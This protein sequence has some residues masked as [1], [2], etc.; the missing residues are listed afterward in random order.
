MKLAMHHQE[1]LQK[2]V[3][4]T[5]ESELLKLKAEASD[6]HRL[7]ADA[8]N[9]QANLANQLVTATNKLLEAERTKVKE[10]ENKFKE[11]ET[12]A[13]EVKGQSE[14]ETVR[15]KRCGTCACR[16][17]SAGKSCERGQSRKSKGSQGCLYGSHG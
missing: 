3:E 8:A 10:L 5:A 16:Y 1:V 17:K 9:E 7:A 15:A 11:L 2:S 13:R 6:A 14:S 4:I 12:E